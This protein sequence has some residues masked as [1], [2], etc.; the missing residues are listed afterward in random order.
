MIPKTDFFDQIE[1]YCQGQLDEVLMLDFESELKI[2]PMLRSEVELWFEIQN[3][4]KEKEIINLRIKLQGVT[5]MQNTAAVSCSDSFE[6]IEEFSDMQ[7]I[8]EILSSEELINFYDSLPKVHAYHHVATS[9]ENIHQFYKNQKES[10]NNRAHVTV[11]EIDEY[12]NGELTGADL[13]EFENDMLQNRSLRSEV[14]LHQD[15]DSAINENDIMNLRGQISN[16]LYTET[17][18]N[19]S[20]KNIEDFIDGVL[21]GELLE[22][23]LAEL[24]DNTDLKAE[25]ELRKQV[26]ESVG[27]TDIFNLR[28]ELRAAKDSAEVKKVKMLIPESKIGTLR[29][30]RSSVAILIVLLGIAGVLRNSF[31]SGDKVYE[32]YFEVPAWSPERSLS[33]E[34]TLLQRANSS[35]LN[36]DFAQVINILNQVPESSIELPVFD[37]Y[38]A[39]SFQKLEKLDDAI[40]SYTKVINHGD[41]LFIE[42]SEWYRSLCYLKTGNKERAKVELL[43]VIE[44]KG[45]FE[46][47]AKAV[48]RR[49]KHSIK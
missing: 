48:F 5:Q 14:K 38:K 2:N 8:T 40:A 15:I 13:I 17:S 47:D 9:N 16:I 25:V 18:W 34:I 44:R 21:E 37:F 6:L 20:E 27:E 4:I 43:A 7:E 35:Y 33:E 41:N 1:D 12:I 26:N 32:K 3:A 23:F 30:W 28:N 10:L 42:E 22:E 46:D 36:G 31:I 11:E 24:K 49:L 19:V 39:A 29:F 45:H